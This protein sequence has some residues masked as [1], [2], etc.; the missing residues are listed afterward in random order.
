M[1]EREQ[2]A[3][4]PILYL[5]P[6]HW[7]PRYENTTFTVKVEQTVLMSSAPSSSSFVGGKSNFPAYYFKVDVFCARKT[8]SVCRRYSQFQWL[9]KRLP[10]I[11]DNGELPPLPPGTCFCQPQNET[12]AQNRLEQLREFLRDIL[13]RP[14]YS[15]HPAVI[16]FLELDV[17]A[18]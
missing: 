4:A 6:E 11:D 14:G 9:Y 10:R 17:I 8:R 15:S 16:T 3:S 1:E 5:V 7:S 12:F 13:Q 2:P 18:S